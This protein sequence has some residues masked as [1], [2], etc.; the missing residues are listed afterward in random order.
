MKYPELCVLSTLR[1][2][3][4]ETSVYE[5]NS[6]LRIKRLHYLTILHH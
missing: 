4:C 5:P 2:Y 1:F 3:Q 6:N